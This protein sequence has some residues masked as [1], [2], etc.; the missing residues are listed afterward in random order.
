[1]PGPLFFFAIVWALAWWR[2]NQAD[3]TKMNLVIWG[4]VGM[5]VYVAGAWLLLH[6]A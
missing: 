3:G 2:Y 6:F 5:F 4:S 1:V